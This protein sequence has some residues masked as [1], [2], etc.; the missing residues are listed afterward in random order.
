MGLR[1]EIPVET[2]MSLLITGAAGFIGS[3][4]LQKISSL[5][6]YDKIVVIDNF[7]DFYPEKIKRLNIAPALENKNIKLCEVDIRDLEGCRKIFEDENVDTVIHLAGK[8]G[9][10]PSLEDPLLYEDI[11][12]RGTLTL[13]ELSRKFNV[14]KFIFGSSSSVYGNNKK[15]PFSE[16]DDVNA[17]I[18]PYGATK[19]TCELYCKTY[20]QIYGMPI[21]CLRFF[22]VYGPRQRPDLAI[23]KF[24]RLIKK[25]APIPFFGD[26]TTKRDY[27]FYSDIVNGII[28][29]LGLDCK[30]EII[31]LGNSNPIELRRLIELIETALNKKAKL[32][33][34][35]EQPGDVRV[36]YA[37]IGKANKLLG[38]KP[39]VNI[40][41]GIEIF[42]KWLK[43][44]D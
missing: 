6:L 19:R 41:S 10:R 30:F 9:V 3:H 21:I 7:D 44:D 5:G 40:E 36:T 32:Q 34:L 18:S 2:Q 12:C 23:H 31:N 27:T 43:Q 24:A 4:L 11:N 42:A 16:L 26:G 22:T 37:D 28:S 15:Q 33:K 25:D 8:A 20:N 29:C 1:N 39:E 14:K 38:Y 13:L 17:P 35:P